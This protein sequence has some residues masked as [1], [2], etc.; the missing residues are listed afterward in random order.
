MIQ[1]SCPFF[2]SKTI[3]YSFFLVWGQIWP[4]HEIQPKMYHKSTQTA[5]YIQSLL[6]SAL[7]EEQTNI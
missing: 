5:R 7:C 2:L 1:N 6:K 4:G 3:F